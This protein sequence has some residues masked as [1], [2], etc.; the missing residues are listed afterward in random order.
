MLDAVAAVAEPIASDP[1]FLSSFAV[2]ATLKLYSHTPTTLSSVLLSVLVAA[3]TARLAPIVGALATARVFPHDAHDA[4]DA[5]SVPD[6]HAPS[7]APTPDPAP[8]DAALPTTLEQ[9]RTAAL[10]TVAAAL[11]PA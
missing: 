9:L 10:R 4:H 8:A 2:L 11:A 1:I 6:T 3:A 7:P 5:P